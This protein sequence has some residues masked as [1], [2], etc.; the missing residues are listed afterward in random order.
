MPK[1]TKTTIKQACANLWKSKKTMQFLLIFTEI[2]N[3]LSSMNQFN[4]KMDIALRDKS[5]SKM[6]QNLKK[7][8]KR[9]YALQKRV[10]L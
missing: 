9:V 4:F 1:V 2:I 3:I 7:S 6:G 5:I 10:E 8:I